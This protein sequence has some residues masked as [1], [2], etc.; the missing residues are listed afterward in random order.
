MAYALQ[1]EFRNIQMKGWS[2][3]TLPVQVQEEDRSD[4]YGGHF[5][6]R[7]LFIGNKLTPEEVNDFVN[8]EGDYCQHSYDCCG[9]Y[10][11]RPAK[12]MWDQFNTLV[13]Q[14]WYQNV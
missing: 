12:I 10:Y 9:R 2:G 5:V 1:G 14:D 3:R 4:E 6:T 8:V 13:T 11:A 7:W